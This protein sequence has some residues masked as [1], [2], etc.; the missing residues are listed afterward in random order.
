[1]DGSVEVVVC[2]SEQKVAEM[3]VWLEQGPQTAT[4]D[5][6]VSEPMSFKPF[7]GFKIL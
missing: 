6:V 1:M 5:S 4:V 7:R 2:G 3:A